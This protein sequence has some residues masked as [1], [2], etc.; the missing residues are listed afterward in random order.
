M[1]EKKLGGLADGG[2]NLNGMREMGNGVVRR[3]RRWFA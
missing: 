1:R 3:G 2:Q